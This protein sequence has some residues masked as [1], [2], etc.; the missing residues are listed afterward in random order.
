MNMTLSMRSTP[1]VPDRAQAPGS[2]LVRWARAGALVSLALALPIAASAQQA[3]ARMAVNLRAGPGTE[4]PV[5]ATLGNGQPFNVAGCTSGYGWCDVVMPDGLR[6]W[7]YSDAIDYAYE[8]RRVPLAGYGAAIGVPIV[9]F[10]LGS[11]WG[12]N[13]RDR[14]WYDDRRYWGGRPPPPR[15]G[16]QRPPPSRPEWQPR[17]WQG[18]QSQAE[19][20]Q[21]PEYRRPA[22]GGMTN[23]PPRQEHQGRPQRDPGMRPPG[24]EGGMRPDGGMRQERQDGGRRAEGGMRPPQQQQQQ[25][26]GRRGEPTPAMRNAPGG[27]SG[28]G[29]PAP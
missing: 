27:M 7:V 19:F 13:Y 1:S 21:R 22:P 16:W 26:G 28:G 6:G 12:N 15:Q 3:Y 24:R 8:D 5:V 2:P 25:Q 29:G 23:V 17:P 11:Y 14:S 4:Y 18:P 9:T 20:R 10:A